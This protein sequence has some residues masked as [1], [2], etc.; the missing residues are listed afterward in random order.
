MSKLASKEELQNVKDALSEKL[1]KVSGVT[2]NLVQ[3]NASGQLV[4]ASVKIVPNVEA[5]TTEEKS[6]GITTINQIDAMINKALCWVE[7][8]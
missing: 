1:N 3:L 4:D 8:E 6:V 5:A 2:G 7:L